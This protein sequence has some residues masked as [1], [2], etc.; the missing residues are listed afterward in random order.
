MKADIHP[1]YAEIKVVCTCGSEFTTRSTNGSDLSI[2]V[3]SA[4]HPFYTGKQK[5]VDSAGRVEKFRQKYG[6]KKA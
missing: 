6:M 5:I 3:C 4:C 1:K 2:E